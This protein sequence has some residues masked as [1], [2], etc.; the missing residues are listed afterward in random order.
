MAALKRIITLCRERFA[1]NIRK[2]FSTVLKSKEHSLPEPFK[3]FVHSYNSD[4]VRDVTRGKVT[5]L[6]YFLIDIGLHNLTGLKAPIKI[7]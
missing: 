4:L 6:K 1:F 5:T 7:L 2:F 3:R